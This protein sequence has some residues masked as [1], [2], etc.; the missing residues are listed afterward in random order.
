[1]WKILQILLG[2]TGCDESFAFGGKHINAILILLMIYNLL[3][4]LH[5][6]L[7]SIIRILLY[8]YQWYYYYGINKCSHIWTNQK[9]TRA[10]LFL[11]QP[12]HEISSAC[13]SDDC[14]ESKVCHNRGGVCAARRQL[15]PVANLMT[16]AIKWRIISVRLLSR[17]VV[18]V[19]H[20]DLLQLS[21]RIS[22]TLA[23]P[24]EAETEEKI[25]E[26]GTQLPV[27]RDTTT[28]N[29]VAIKKGY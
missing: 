28:H 21:P 10:V 25:K 11:S 4:T 23:G 7:Y 16:W 29:L 26:D 3:D 8:N 27:C 2:Q 18:R 9:K 15:Q 17:L 5:S 1:M 24:R 13:L 14:E 6:L 20:L 19:S 22:F 12:T